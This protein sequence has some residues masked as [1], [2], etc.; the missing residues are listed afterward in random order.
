MILIFMFVCT[1]LYGG[2]LK[3]KEKKQ[4]YFTS[5]KRITEQQNFRWE[6]IEQ[7]LEES[8]NWR[9]EDKL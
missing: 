4:I 5:E 8:G 6:E 3:K 1:L 9:N 7:T 2:Q